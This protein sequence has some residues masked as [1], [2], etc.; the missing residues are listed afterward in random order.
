MP[1][2][3]NDSVFDFGLTPAE[4]EGLYR[5]LN[6]A[7]EMVTCTCDIATVRSLTAFRGRVAAFTR[8]HP[9]KYGLEPLAEY[10]TGEEF[11]DQEYG[12]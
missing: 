5:S 3:V 4:A 6:V 2:T 9:T 12:S 7:L 11:G 1:T 8:K 10:D